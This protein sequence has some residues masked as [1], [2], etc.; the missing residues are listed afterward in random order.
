M[1]IRRPSISSPDWLFQDFL[2]QET[3]EGE[4]RYVQVKWDG[5]PYQTISSTFDYSNPPFPDPEQRGGSIV[6]QLDYNIV[7]QLVTVTGWFVN[8]RDEWPLRLAFNYLTNCKY[9]STLGY[10]IRAVGEEV[11]KQDGTPVDFGVK[12]PYAFLVSENF[13]PLTDVPNEYFIK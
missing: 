9:P 6:A 7:G 3:P 4:E 11:Y 13:L 5:T 10:V 12:D 8:W 2:Y 1:A